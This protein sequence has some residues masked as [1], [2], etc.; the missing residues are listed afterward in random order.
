MLGDLVA[1][2]VSDVIAASTGSAAGEQAAGPKA[3]SNVAGL[4][5]LLYGLCSLP[6][7]ISNLGVRGRRGDTIDALQWAAQSAVADVL[8]FGS[9]S[10]TACSVLAC[11]LASGLTVE[12]R[13]DGRVI[14]HK[15]PGA[16]GNCHGRWNMHMTKTDVSTSL[17]VHSNLPVITVIAIVIC[18]SSEVTIHNLWKLHASSHPYSYA[19]SW[20]LVIVVTICSVIFARLTGAPNVQYAQTWRREILN[21]WIAGSAEHWFTQNSFSDSLR[22]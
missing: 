10:V 18:F 13:A 19:S 22:Q 8:Q 20:Q 5:C 6:A 15:L 1:S 4:P 14:P 11:P 7:K 3:S 21:V 9:Q 12:K 16:T 17:L 2:T